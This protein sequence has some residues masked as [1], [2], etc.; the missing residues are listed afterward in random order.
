MRYLASATSYLIRSVQMA[1]PLFSII[2]TAAK[3]ATTAI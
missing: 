3:T 1:R 2:G